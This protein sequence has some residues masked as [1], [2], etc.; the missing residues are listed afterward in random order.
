MKTLADVENE[1]KNDPALAA[2]V[3][4]VQ[5]LAVNYEPKEQV[6][7][8]RPQSS[9][10]LYELT[11]DMF[12]RIAKLASLGWTQGHILEGVGLG[13]S[14]WQRLRK[15]AELFDQ[16]KD[17]GGAR[18]AIREIE[19]AIAAG[20]TAWREWLSLVIQARIVTDQSPTLAILASKQA[21]GLD[22]KEKADGAL[23]DGTVR[24]EV[25]HRVIYKDGSEVKIANAEEGQIKELPQ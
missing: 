24:V 5:P 25:T 15:Q 21:H 22:W 6:A 4:S 10:L 3:E 8:L 14:D 17:D 13:S 16:G 2:A 20:R 23:E 18:Y 7:V 1:A 11:W 19:R 12:R 9:E